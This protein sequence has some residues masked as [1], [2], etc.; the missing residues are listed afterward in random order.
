M[1]LTRHSGSQR[2]ARRE[3]AEVQDAWRAAQAQARAERLTRVL[4]SHKRATDQVAAQLRGLDE[5]RALEAERMRE[6]GR[7]RDAQLWERIEAVIR[8][9]E[10][11]A[12][13]RVEEERLRREAE[14]RRRREEVERKLAEERRQAEEAARKQAEEDERRKREEAE[15][16]EKKRLEEAEHAQAEMA[17]SEERE[18]RALGLTTADDDWRRARGT[19]M[20]CALLIH[21]RIY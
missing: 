19:L 4:A 2:T 8:V 7:A 10:E 17:Q 21:R 14:E 5:R 16:E 3:R 6:H 20:V 1:P 18:R 12:R 15:E 13:Q 11:R 9:E